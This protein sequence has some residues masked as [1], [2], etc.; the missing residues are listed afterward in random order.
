MSDRITLN[1]LLREIDRVE[2]DQT[3]HEA[4]CALRYK[5]LTNAID[6]LKSVQNQTFK[7]G[8]GLLISVI[9][10]LAVQFWNDVS[11]G[12]DQAQAAEVKRDAR[13]G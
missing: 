9:G 13:E 10:W 2:A 6:E 1:S 8:V 5:E 11:V 4:E 7:L 12:I 3:R